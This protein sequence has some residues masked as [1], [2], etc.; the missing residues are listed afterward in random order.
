MY[1]VMIA[2]LLVLY[3]AMDLAERGDSRTI[4]A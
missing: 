2:A 4:E 3:V 1:L